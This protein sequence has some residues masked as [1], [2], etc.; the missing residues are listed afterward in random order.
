[1]SYIAEIKALKLLI[2]PSVFSFPCDS[3][4]SYSDNAMESKCSIIASAGLDKTLVPATSHLGSK[5]RQREWG[6]QSK[7]Q[8]TK[9]CQNY[10]HSI[11]RHQWSGAEGFIVASEFQVVCS[12]DGLGVKDCVIE[13][14]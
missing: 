8:A 14:M 12:L 13:A 3:S 9:Q 1:M 7:L 6:R 2:T 4:C 11:C 5:G 10:K